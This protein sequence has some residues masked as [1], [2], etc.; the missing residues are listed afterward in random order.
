MCVTIA[1]NEYSI[2]MEAY[3]CGEVWVVP[4]WAIGRRCYVDVDD[5]KGSIFNDERA[6]LVLNGSATIEKVSGCKGGRRY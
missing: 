1:H 3:E 6:A 5:F 2:P 4:W